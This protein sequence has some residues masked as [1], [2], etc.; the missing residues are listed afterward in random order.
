MYLLSIII[1]ITCFGMGL[2]ANSIVDASGATLSSSVTSTTNEA[3]AFIT[4]LAPA[5]MNTL[6]VLSNG[7]QAIIPAILATVLNSI[8]TNTALQNSVQK[9]NNSLIRLKS[10]IDL[11]LMNGALLDNQISNLTLL[12]LGIQQGNQDTIH[13]NQSHYPLALNDLSFNLASLNNPI[14][15]TQSDGTF[16][17]MTKFTIPVA[18]NQSSSLLSSITSGS[19]PNVTDQLSILRPPSIPDL[20]GIIMNFTSSYNGLNNQI[21]SILYDKLNNVTTLPFI[22]AQAQIS[23][24]IATLRSSAQ[25]NITAFQNGLM[26]QGQDAFQQYNTLR[27][28]I[29]VIVLCVA[30]S[31]LI[32]IIIASLM[33]KGSIMIE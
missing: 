18:L 4:N 5:I 28:Y 17:I 11:T 26:K 22:N 15:E 8:S 30:I 12:S 29:T 10:S 24:S 25:G 9:T 23:A 19:L 14:N 27:S 31:T 32:W 3:S 7:T 21:S 13:I 20:A 1:S 6:D 2:N 33:R 16:E